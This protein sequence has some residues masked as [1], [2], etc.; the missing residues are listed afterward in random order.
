MS[1]LGLQ[2]VVNGQWRTDPSH[3]VERD[4]QGNENNVL[5]PEDIK[6]DETSGGSGTS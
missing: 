4:S 1:L 5:D 3:A 2:Y 6:E